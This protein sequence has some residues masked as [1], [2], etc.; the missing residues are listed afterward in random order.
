MNLPRSTYYHQSKSR[1]GG[2]KA[3][4]IVQLRRQGPR[5]ARLP[6]PLQKLPNGAAG[7]P[8]ARGDLLIGQVLLPFQ[9]KDFSNV[10]HEQPHC[11]HR[12]LL[13]VFAEDVPALQRYIRCHRTPVEGGGI[14]RNQVADC[15]GI[16]SFR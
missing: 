12:L 8:A 3:L 1:P 14:N 2:E 10:A 5:K 13:G 7:G 16:R 4:R 6:G 9:S 15:F 11:R